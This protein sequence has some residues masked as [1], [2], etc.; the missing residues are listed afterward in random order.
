MRYQNGK[1]LN[2]MNTYKK[3]NTKFLINNFQKIITFHQEFLRFYE[4][5]NIIITAQRVGMASLLRGSHPN[6]TQI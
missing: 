5:R 1:K 3:I 4:F 6:W 2:H